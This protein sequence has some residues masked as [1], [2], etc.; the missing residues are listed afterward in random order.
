MEI[1]VLTLF[2]EI[3]NG[4][5]D[6]SILKRAR[7]EGLI[8]I[9]AVNIRDFATDRHKTTDDV[10]YGGGPG[11]VMKVGPVHRAVQSV[12]TE[13][14]LVVLMTPGG[15]RFTQKWAERLAG[16]EKLVFICGHYEGIDERV[17]DIV[18]PLPLS[19]GD[20]VMTNGALAACVVIDAVARLIPGV[21]GNPDSIREES[22]CRDG[23]EYPQYTRPENYMGFRVPEILRSGNHR[24]IE[25]WRKA[26]AEKRTRELADF[27]G[28]VEGDEYE[29]DH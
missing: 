22:F 4:P 25:T 29:R 11:M 17:R 19:I 6:Q 24:E 2:P 28:G 7:K 20:F 26:Q 15:H 21:L 5:L 12:L 1:D 10:P 9:R 14:S 23:V 27:P 3:L 13:K 16:E 8:R 18:N